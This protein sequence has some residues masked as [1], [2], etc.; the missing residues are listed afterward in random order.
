MSTNVLVSSMPPYF[1][2]VLD[3]VLA[4]SAYPYHHTHLRYLVE[5]RIHTVISVSPE[6][7]PPFHTKPD[8]KVIRMNISQLQAPSLQEC[9]QF[10]SYVEHAKRRNEVIFY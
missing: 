6:E 3:G 10:V 2:W 8:L 7:E 1:S 5:N 4:I 9:Q